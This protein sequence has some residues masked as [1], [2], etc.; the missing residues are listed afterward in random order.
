MESNINF[1]L[2][3]TLKKEILLEIYKEISNKINNDSYYKLIKEKK[4]INDIE[5]ENN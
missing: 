5:K 4:E 2:I 1:H 3:K